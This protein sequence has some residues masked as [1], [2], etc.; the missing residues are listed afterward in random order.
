MD[1]VQNCDSCVN[2]PSSQTC[3]SYLQT[4]LL[5]LIKNSVAIVRERTIQIERPPL[6]GVVN[7]NIC[8]QRGVPWSARRI[9]MAVLSILC[10]YISSL[11]NAVELAGAG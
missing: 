3:R 8:G 6:V 2:I 5:S 10:L 7:A 11:Q 4:L 9:S 1:D